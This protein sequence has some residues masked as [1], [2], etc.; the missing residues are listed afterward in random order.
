MKSKKQSRQ[1]TTKKNVENHNTNNN[2]QRVVQAQPEHQV[3]QTNG[4][5][6]PTLLSKITCGLCR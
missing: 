4:T 3:N 5:K 2:A 1:N 6:K